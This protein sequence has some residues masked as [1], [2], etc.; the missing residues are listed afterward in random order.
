MKKNVKIIIGI[1]FSLYILLLLYLT[2]FSRMDT[3]HFI[4][5]RS[6]F[7]DYIKNSFNIIPFK[8]ILY[9]FQN[10][11]LKQVFLNIMGNIIAFMPFAF[12]L[13]YAFKKNRK[14]KPFL[15]SLTLI[16][17]S[18]ESIQLLT[19]S[20]S[21]DIDDIILNVTGALLF[22]LFLQSSSIK[23]TLEHILLKDN[24]KVKNSKIY[25]ILLLALL[26]FSSVICFIIYEKRETHA[27]Q[28]YLIQKMFLKNSIN[29][30]N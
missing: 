2:L 20:G 7:D 24:S 14:L 18:I 30:N 12:F 27:S 5:E 29:L 19:V 13:P 6:R 9:I 1:S 8:S 26:I 3:L 16:S 21:F 28:P 17:F 15:L 25:I 22:Y 10:L 4:W 11:T 23:H